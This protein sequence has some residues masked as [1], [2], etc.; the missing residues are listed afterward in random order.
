MMNKLMN[1]YLFGLILMLIVGCGNPYKT[2]YVVSSPSKNIS[3]EFFL[4]ID[5]SP[6]YLVNHKGIIAID[7]S[8]M[9]FDFK[10]QPSM[11]K[12]FRIIG[13]ET[14][15]VNEDWEMPWGEQRIVNNHYNGLVIKLEEEQ[16][17]NR[18]LNIYF[19]A[20]ND[21]IGFR[22]E[23]PEQNGVDSVIIIDENTHFNLT[24]DHTCWWIP[25]DWDIYEHLY[26]TTKFSD[27]DALTKR[28]HPN[29]AQTYI[30]ENAVNTPVTMRTK[31]GLHLSFHEANLTD[32]A[33]MTLK[34]DTES[35][36]MISELVGS[37]RLG[38]KVKRALPFTTPWRT[39]QIT[40][41]AKELIASNLIVNLNEPNRLGN[42]T[43]FKPKKYVGIWWEMHIGKSSW[44]FTSGKHGATTE[45]AK[46]YI[47]FAAANNITG[48]LLEG[49]NTG[50]DY[51]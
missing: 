20:Y 31:D 36:A 16:A 18:K 34:V 3:V 44:D 33:G 9:G 50:W 10:Y 6:N 37:D 51:Y 41:T 19:R 24:G 27:I 29:L 15:A 46:K 14:D 48:V 25:G 30:P 39:V 7:T 21:G 23:F 42:I 1:L 22:Y 4:K 12:G 32:Y 38:Y 26:N 13:S 35:L 45:N 17:P 2:A 40:E 11:G 49:W 43:W 5:G 28:N 47:D 8:I